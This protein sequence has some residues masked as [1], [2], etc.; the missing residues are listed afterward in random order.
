MPPYGRELG[1]ANGL[2]VHIS[3]EQFSFRFPNL[4]FSGGPQ[5]F[6]LESRK[7]LPGGLSVPLQ[8]RVFPPMYRF[9]KGL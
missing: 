9:S 7:M 1:C 5:C 6:R 4:G 8:F 2:R 3:P